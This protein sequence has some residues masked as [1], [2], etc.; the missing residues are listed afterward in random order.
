[1]QFTREPQLKYCIQSS[2][3]KKYLFILLFIYLATPGLSCSMRDLHCQV[4]DLLVVGSSSLAR[5]RTRAPC[6]GSAEA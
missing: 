1:M 4:Q 5:D 2:F 3:F 6:I